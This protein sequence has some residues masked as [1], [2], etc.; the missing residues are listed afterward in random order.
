MSILRTGNKMSSALQEGLGEFNIMRD[1]AIEGTRSMKG[2]NPKYFGFAH[3]GREVEMFFP[4]DNITELDNHYG[5]DVAVVVPT[6]TGTF[7]MLKPSFGATLN[8]KEPKTI[9]NYL[10]KLLESI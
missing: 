9:R 5:M 2:K 7:D 8:M 1:N 4:K 10:R 3:R 6:G